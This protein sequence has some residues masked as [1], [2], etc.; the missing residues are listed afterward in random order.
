MKKG[1]MNIF[2]L[3]H[4]FILRRGSLSQIGVA[5]CIKFQKEEPKT[6]LK[7]FLFFAL[8]G[9]SIL[10]HEAALFFFFVVFLFFPRS[11]FYVSHHG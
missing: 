6:G 7:A 3:L 9:C 4:H 11:N 8:Q 2:D 1:M 5:V 10:D